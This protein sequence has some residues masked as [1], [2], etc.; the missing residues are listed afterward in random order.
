[1]FSVHVAAVTISCTMYGYTWVSS[2]CS[3]FISSFK[4]KGNICEGERARRGVAGEFANECLSFYWRNELCW[5][6]SELCYSRQSWKI[7]TIKYEFSIWVVKNDAQL[8]IEKFIFQ[9]TCQFII[10]NLARISYFMVHKLMHKYESDLMCRVK[11]THR[12]YVLIFSDPIEE[13]HPSKHS[14]EKFRPIPFM[15]HYF[16]TYLLPMKKLTKSLSLF[17]KRFDFILLQL[18]RKVDLGHLRSE[19][20]SW[21]QQIL[22]TKKDWLMQIRHYY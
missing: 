11:P 4:A 12:I 18:K 21:M 22:N 2:S 19:T 17:D 6:H 15:Y 14:C 7:N 13:F 1:M 9:N 5:M 3:I 16:L 10:H 20:F 8:R